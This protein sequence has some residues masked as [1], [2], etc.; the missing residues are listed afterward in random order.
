VLDPKL[1][2]DLF[3]NGGEY[4]FAFVHVHVRDACMAAHGV[5]AA[6][7]GPDVHVVDFLHKF[8]GED[9]AGD[10]FDSRFARPAFQKD[11]RG[12]AQNAG[13]GIEDEQTDGKPKQ[14]IDPVRV[15][16][17]HDNRARDDGN[18]GEGIAKVVHQ[19][20]AKVQ[21]GVPADEGQR[22]AAVDK[23]GRQG[24]PD[25]PALDDFHRSA[26]ALD[27]FVAQPQRKQN[28]KDR[29]GERRERPGAM[30]SVGSLRIGRPLRPTHGQ[31]G[32]PQRGDIRKV[33]DRV[34]QQRDGMTKNAAENFRDNQAERRR[35]GP[36]QNGWPHRW[37]RVAMAVGMTVLVAV[38]LSVMRFVEV[39]LFHSTSFVTETQL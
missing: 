16:V 15:G 24:G 7:E 34:V 26:Q 32:N 21:V 33:V 30:I 31:P 13:R 20:A 23:Q 38:F 36:R 9:G 35:H 27:G 19:D 14:G 3:L 22:D 8:H 2:R 37:V 18:V 29:I 17:A 10:L 1:F 5:M 39:H 28:E 4:F 12:L 6:A 25:H 11:V